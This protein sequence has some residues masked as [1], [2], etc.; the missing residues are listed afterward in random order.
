MKEEKIVLTRV[1]TPHGELQLQQLAQTDE[2]GHPVYEVIFNGIFLIASYN[3]LSEK[4]VAALAIE[5]LA[6]KRGAL[7]VLIGGLGIGYSLCA[8]LDYESVREVDVVE[9]EEHIIRWAMGLFRKH[10]G[11][12]CSDPRVS[13][14]QMDLGDYILQT[15]KAYDAI[16]VDVDNGPTWLALE[17][18]KRLYEGPSLRGFKARLK[19]RGVLTVWAAQRSE[20]F[21]NRLE[22]VFGRAELIT[23]QD[24]DGHGRQIDYFIYRT[25]W[26]RD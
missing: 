7:R 16:I 21:Q 13:I 8:A 9:I 11:N 20:E 24:V 2:K 12:A 26:L 3:K 1:T 23:V 15:D 4:A 25:R 22:R 14:I 6:S 10:N 18:N 19:D 17:G 5:P